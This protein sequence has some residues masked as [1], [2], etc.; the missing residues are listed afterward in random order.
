VRVISDDLKTGLAAGL[1]AF[2]DMAASLSLFQGYLNGP[3]SRPLGV[4]V[5]G[6]GDSVALLCLLWL[7]GQR[8]LHVFTVDHGIN[9]LSAEWTRGVEALCA[10]L[11]VGVSV[12]R[13]TGEKPKTGLQAA[14]RRARHHLILDAARDARVRVICLGHNADDAAEA[15]AMRATGS[16]VSGPQLWSP[17]PFW[18]QGEGIFYF[19]PLMGVGRQYLRDWLKVVG[20]AYVDDPAN[21]NPAYLR[22]RVR[23]QGVTPFAGCEASSPMPSLRS[24]VE[25]AVEAPAEGTFFQVASLPSVSVLSAMI[26]CAGGGEKLPRRSEVGRIAGS[27]QTGRSRFT[28]CGAR[29]E[30]HEGGWLI[31]REPGD[32]TRNGTGPRRY[33]DIWDGRFRLPD[34]A[35][36]S[37]VVAAKGWLGHLSADDQA[38]LRPLPAPVRA[39]LPVLKQGETVRLFPAG[40]LQDLTCERLRAAL[41]QIACEASLK[42]PPYL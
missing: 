4:A 31:C 23:R 21:D 13:W 28:L 15:A 25:M 9:P 38:R 24:A 30:G 29:I 6:G 36:L 19:R 17:A 11:G 40:D 8:P 10:R 42:S 2:P 34:Y 14:A 16:N 3:A 5:S 39:A 27:A 26:V 7:W 20:V 1:D 41:G 37:D 18:P 32:M 35:R 33:G 12:L 22:A